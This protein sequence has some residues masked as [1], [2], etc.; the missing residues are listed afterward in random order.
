MIRY[1]H[2]SGVTQALIASVSGNNISAVEIAIVLNIY[3]R[4]VQKA[5][6][7]RKEYD[8]SESYVP[9]ITPSNIKRIRISPAIQLIIVKWV[10]FNTTPSTKQE[11]IIITWTENGVPKQH[12]LHYR[13]VSLDD[14]YF[15]FKQTHPIISLSSSYFYFSLPVWLSLSVQRSGLCIYHD[16][17]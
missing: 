17:A 6:R 16:K 13:T 3:K 12:V 1:K 7:K 4:T 2:Q 5:R 15:Q 14:L 8:E 11:N 9:L 10:E